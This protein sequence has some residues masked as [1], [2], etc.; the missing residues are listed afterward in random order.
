MT[1]KVTLLVGTTKGLF[2]IDEA[3]G[4]WA[5]SGPH[6]GGWPINHAVGDPDTGTHTGTWAT[7]APVQTLLVAT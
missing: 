6:C 3:D 1:R 5:V 2:L 7:G 4:G